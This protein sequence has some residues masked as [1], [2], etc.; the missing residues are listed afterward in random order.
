MLIVLLIW[1]PGHVENKRQAKLSGTAYSKSGHRGNSL[2][3]GAQLF[4]SSPSSSFHNF[5]TICLPKIPFNANKTALTITAWPF[6]AC[7]AAYHSTQS[8]FSACSATIFR[9]QHSHKWSIFSLGEVWNEMK[10]KASQHHKPS[11]ALLLW[12]N[13][14]MS[15]AVCSVTCRGESWK[16]FI[17]LFLHG[18]LCALAVCFDVRKL[19]VTD[20]HLWE[21]R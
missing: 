13:S 12:Q 10:N 7:G 14:D 5:T 3:R 17:F 4:L 15:S 6:R 11:A 18:L 8:R 9:W 1:R 16:S 21:N 19:P 20:N 2:S